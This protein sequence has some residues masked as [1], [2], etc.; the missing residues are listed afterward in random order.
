VFPNFDINLLFILGCP[1]RCGKLSTTKS[2]VI[3]GD[4][5]TFQFSVDPGKDIAWEKKVET[6]YTQLKDP[7]YIII[8]VQEKRVH[9]LKILETEYSNSGEY[10]VNCGD[11]VSNS[12]YLNIGN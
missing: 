8:V 9:N 7:K 4:P 6:T 2:Y 3:E 12:I 10:R 1:E 5:V 11:T